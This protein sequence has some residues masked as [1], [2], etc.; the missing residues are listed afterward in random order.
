MG[1]KHINME[2]RK[3]FPL[4]INE[5][6][7]GRMYL[8]CNQREIYNLKHIYQKRRN[9]END[10]LLIQL[11]KLREESNKMKKMERNNKCKDKFNM[12]VEKK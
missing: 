6:R 2:I 3:D 9:T 8:N 10:Y 7:I 12:K 11:K 5:N 1:K 4:N